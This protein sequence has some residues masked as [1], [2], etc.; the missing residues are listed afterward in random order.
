[1]IPPIKAT[2]LSARLP[3]VCVR[4]FTFA[5]L[6]RVI[7]SSGCERTYVIC[8][9]ISVGLSGFAKNTI[10]SSAHSRVM[11]RSEIISG[12]SE[13]INSGIFNGDACVREISNL[14]DHGATRQS[15]AE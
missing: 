4:A 10:L 3:Q 5:L 15:A 1:M 2:I 13:Y 11:V 9:R 12:G 8:F 6:A 7:A 14:P